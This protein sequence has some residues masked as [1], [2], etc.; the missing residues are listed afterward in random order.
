MNSFY[1]GL[2]KKVSWLSVVF[3]LAVV[4]PV[5]AATSQSGLAPM[6][7]RI[8]PAIV[9]LSVRGELHLPS[10]LGLPHSAP[11][12]YKLPPGNSLPS[13]YGG[14]YPPY[15]PHPKFQSMGSGV[16]VDAKKGYI[17]T[18]A[19]VIRNADIITV[20][21]SDGRHLMGK[22]VGIDP[23]SDIAIIRVRAKNLKAL[24][25]IKDSDS[26][27]I[28]ETVAA[29]GNPFGLKQTVTAGVVS[30]LNRHLGIEM[31]ENFIQTDAPIN[32]G[33][34]GG[35]LVNAK[36]ELIGIN[37][38]I[39]S[40]AGASVG[41]G[42][43]IPGNM[44]QGIMQQLIKYGKV[45]RGLLG[46]R[47]QDLTP[48]LADAFKM[49]GM[50]G[51]LITMVEPG[52]AANEAGLRAED[53][54]QSINGKLIYSGDQVRSI[55]GSMRKDTKISLGIRRHNKARYIKAIIKD[56]K[57]FEDKL[58]RSQSPL[59]GLQLRTYDQIDARGRAVK[60][61]E[62][63]RISDHSLAWFSGVRTGDVITALNGLQ[64][65]TINAL[66]DTMKKEPMPFLLKLQRLSG[67]I[68]LVVGD[69]D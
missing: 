23:A 66:L 12:P 18:N 49:S 9:N 37:T 24:T 46:V 35:A 58:L 69:K 62:V 20:S 45:E 52:S 4:A 54:I 8:M 15:L 10:S 1:T 53:V 64:T 41:I 57:L 42:F 40:P 68:Y 29:L 34:S 28:G 25:F 63:L 7:K 43:A 48:A 39:L 26:V 61:V 31:Y 13:P 6:L 55:V 44:V 47:V 59:S 17:V 33:N 30:G 67:T 38:A 36:G 51:A 50:K 21:L 60:G 19:H 56:P 22:K 11:S 5:Y 65:P 16:I 2:A 27:E 14:G 3:S 32:P